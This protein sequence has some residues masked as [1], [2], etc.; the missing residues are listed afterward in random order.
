MT[1]RARQNPLDRYT[2]IGEL[3]E[4]VRFATKRVIAPLV[5]VLGIE[6]AYLGLS[7]HPGAGAFALISAGTCLAL[8]VWSQ[9]G[10]GLPLLPTCLLYT[11]RCV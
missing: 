9:G 1:A 6:T 2:N 11:S 5:L 3:S 8:L 7:G 10:I 4:K